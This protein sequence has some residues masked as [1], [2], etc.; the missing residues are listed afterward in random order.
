MTT[1]YSL[2][3]PEMIIASSA[4]IVSLI[5]AFVSIYSAF[6]DR[7]YAL[8]SVWPRLEI[9]RSFGDNHFSY[10]VSNK[11]TGPAV[12]QYAQMTSDEQLIRSWPEYLHKITGNKVDHVQSHIGEKVLS[13]GEQIRP[14]QITDAESVKMLATHDSLNIAL[15]Y[16]SIYHECW[17]VDRAN[18][19]RPITQCT[20][21]DK[22]RFLQ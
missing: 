6:I 3:N 22:Q 10:I 13:D 19:P 9:S 15:C 1:G 4:L 11:G 20:I 5:T 2:R 8:A 7:A 16:C 17:L 12:I 14:L 21:D 18:Q